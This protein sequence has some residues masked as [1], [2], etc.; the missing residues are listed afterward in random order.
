MKDDTD[1][2]TLEELES[3]FSRTPEEEAEHEK[4]VMEKIKYFDEHP[5]E[6]PDL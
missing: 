3:M 6:I 1:V 5:D 4:E 2:C